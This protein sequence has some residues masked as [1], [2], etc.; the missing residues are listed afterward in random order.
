VGNL[1]IAKAHQAGRLQV[2]DEETLQRLTAL[3]PLALFWQ[4]QLDVLRF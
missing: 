3:F 2:A 1:N 4:S